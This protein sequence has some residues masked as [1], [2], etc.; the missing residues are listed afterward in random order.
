MT[1]DPMATAQRIRDEY[2][3]RAAYEHDVATQALHRMIT[4][5]ELANV[6]SYATTLRDTLAEVGV[7]IER[8]RF[9]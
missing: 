3:K 2:L 9:A 8:E 4:F 6:D 5:C 7:L 1:T